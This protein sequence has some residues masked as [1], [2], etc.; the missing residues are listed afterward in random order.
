MDGQEPPPQT[1]AE[2]LARV[3][4]LTVREIEVGRTGKWWK[5]ISRRCYATI[6]APRTYW[7]DGPP[8]PMWDDASSWTKAGDA[9]PA[10]APPRPFRPA[11]AKK[12]RKVA[13]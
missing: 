10:I 13:A 1:V 2:A 9:L 5:V 6:G 8:P 11:A 12:R 3:G 7:A 4:E